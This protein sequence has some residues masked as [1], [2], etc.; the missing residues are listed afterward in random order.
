MADYLTTT[1]GAEFAHMGSSGSPAFEAGASYEVIAADP[2]DGC[3]TI[4]QATA[5]NQLLLVQRGTCTFHE[6][7]VAAQE[8]GY[9]AAFIHNNTDGI[10]NATV[11]GETPITIPVATLTQADG[12]AL[13]A[14]IQAGGTTVTFADE[15]KAFDNPT[16]GYQSDFSSYGLAADLTLKPDVS[17]PVGSIYSTYPLEENGYTTMSGTSMSAPH[18]AGAAAI[19]LEAKPE[20]DPFGVRTTLTNTADPFVWGTVADLGVLEPVHRQGGGMIDIPQAIQTAVTIEE[21]KISL[22]EGE[23]GPV[24]TELTV[25]NA[26]DEEK[27]FS[28]GVEHGVATYGPTNNPGFYILDADV[29]FSADSITVPAGQTAT[30]TAVI[31]ESFVDDEGNQLHGAIYGG[32][33]TLNSET[34]QFVVPFAGLSGDYQALTAL[35][36]AAMA[37]VDGE[38]LYVAEPFHEYSMVGDDVPYIYF[39]LAYPVQALYF[40][41]YQAN[42]DGTKGKKVHSNFVNYATFL[43]EGRFQ[44]A[45]TLPWDGTYQGNNGKNGKLRR[46]ADGD[47]VL[48]VRVL[49]A[50]GDPNNPEHWESW[51]STPITIAYGEGAD[52]DAGNGAGAGKGKGN[53]GN[54]GKGKGKGNA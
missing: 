4:P 40:D 6:K 48:E 17:A 38:S 47:Y 5:D 52:T 24:T 15:P 53:N 27:T 50:L 19:L 16:G 32:W 10:I 3:T 37:F 41:V 22:G 30:F 21:S 46:V 2:I 20:L 36:L 9:A 8:H 54:N 12:E 14:E 18:V 1:G 13:L 34:E 23:A 31:G 11:E 39:N 7:A 51:D 35:D 43:D 45:I 44:S 49:K 25:T 29:E 28:I 42:A 26:S 33:V